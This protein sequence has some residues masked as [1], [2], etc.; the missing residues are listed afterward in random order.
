MRCSIEKENEREEETYVECVWRNL[1]NELIEKTEK[2]QASPSSS[3]S[4]SM[5]IV[6]V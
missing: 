4:S 5:I 3:S 2:K 1:S 6:F